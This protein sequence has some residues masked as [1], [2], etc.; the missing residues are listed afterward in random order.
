MGNRYNRHTLPAHLLGDFLNHD[1]EMGI[2]TWKSRD[3]RWFQSE[4]HCRTWNTR[5]SGKPALNYVKGNGY[6]EGSILDHKTYA[7]RAIWAM[8]HGDWPQS[9]VD[10]INGV[11]TDN[12]I[13][14]LRLATRSQNCMNRPAQ[15][16]SKTGVKGVWFRRD[17]GKFESAIW[18][19]SRKHR[20]GVFE[21]LAEAQEAY[22]N[23][24]TRLH[25][26]FAKGG[27]A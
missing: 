7:H 2:L 6:L 14:N 12:R 24:A 22:A 26:E 9:D 23:A 20:V 4:G 19:R 3:S 8:V 21:T 25:G 1:P 15:S 5:Y 10:H 13:A 18:V 17:I 27:V 16:N 11:K